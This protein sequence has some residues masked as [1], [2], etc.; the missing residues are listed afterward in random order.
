LADTVEGLTDLHEI[1]TAILRSALAD[2]AL[3]SGLRLRIQ[4]MQQR[5]ERLEDR[6][7][8]RRGIGRGGS[9]VGPTPSTITARSSS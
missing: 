9:S 4:E 2:Q 5:L 7:S 8:K 3:A 6:A 1:V